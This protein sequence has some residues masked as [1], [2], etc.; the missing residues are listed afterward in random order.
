MGDLPGRLQYRK[1]PQEF[2]NYVSKNSKLEVVDSYY[3][4]FNKQKSIEST[5]QLLDKHKDLAFIY[6]GSTDIALG[7]SEVLE[8]RGLTGKILTN[9]WGGGS[10]ELKAIEAGLLDITVMRINDDNGIA[11]AEAVKLDLEGKTKQV[12]TVFSGDFETV[13][14]G[15]K[16][17]KIELLKK[18]AFRYSN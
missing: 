2:I 18:R 6:A 11:M 1:N 13:K 4:D 16:K 3:T 10:N 12:P 5:K 14:K 7:V 9:G 17:D 15:I 8:Q